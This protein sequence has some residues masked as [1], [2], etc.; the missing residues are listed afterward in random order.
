MTKGTKDKN[1][2][3]G[4]IKYIFV[5]LFVPVFI[6]VI[7][8]GTKMDYNEGLKLVTKYDNKLAVIIA[9]IG[10]FVVAFLAKKAGKIK[11]DAKTEGIADCV[12]AALTFILYRIE[13]LIAR[14]TAFKLPWDI[15]VVRGTANT[16][17]RGEALGSDVYISVYHNNISIAYILGRLLKRA[18]EKGYQGDP[19]F[20]W[21]EIGCLLMA[22]SVFF[23]TLLI[24]RITKNLAITAAG[25]LTLFVL[26]GLSGWMFATYTDSYG[27]LF[28]VAAVYFYI[29]YRQSDKPYIKIPAILLSCLLG[30]V[31]YF[32]K[33]S[34]FIVLIAMAAC[35]ILGLIRKPRSSAVYF[36]VF[37][38]SL[39]AVVVGASKYKEKASDELGF[40]RIENLAAGVMDYFYMGQNE[41]TTGSYSNEDVTVF[42]EFQFE[43]KSVREKAC[44]ER[45][46]NR[47]KEKGIVGAPYFWLKKMVMTFNDGT[48]GWRGEVWIANEYWPPVCSDT[49]RT[50]LLR[51]I[52][53]IDGFHELKFNTLM[54]QVWIFVLTGLFVYPFI[55]RKKDGESE[56]WEFLT[57]LFIG[58]FLYQ[59]LLEARAR[60]LFVFLPV[61]IAMAMSGISGLSNKNIEKWRKRD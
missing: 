32:V 40:D 34:I 48:F 4:I 47:I 43:E 12:I 55:E 14:E 6:C 28:P 10:I 13:L 33:P 7:M 60:Y 2:I 31:G 51:D 49:K 25:F 46:I 39:C 24:K 20:Y 37:M 3:S 53:R 26:V 54:Q 56:T 18:Q 16:F 27:I 29:T 35:E 45:A 21:V 58:V 5:I 22:L 61:I 17:A 9:V 44:F 19:E 23:G 57:V 8:L 11:L 41:K 1:L 42:G 36:A 38:I 59:V 15:G 52:W 50:R 30:A